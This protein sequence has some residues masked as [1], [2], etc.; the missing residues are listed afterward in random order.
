MSSRHQE[1]GQVV[2]EYVLLLVVAVTVAAIIVKTM[3]SRE[4]ANPGIAIRSWTNITN[5]IGKD[6]A[7]SP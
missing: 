7:D 2:I 5:T 3:T 4:P 6:A 1:K